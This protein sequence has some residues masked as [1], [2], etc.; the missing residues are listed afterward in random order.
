MVYY[1]MPLDEEAK[2]LCVIS[3]PWGLYPCEVLPQGVKPATDIF[4]QQMNALFHD[5][6]NVDT[7]IL[8]YTTFEAHLSD[9]IEVLKRSAAG[10]QVNAEKCKWFMHSAMHL[11]FVITR[12][13]IQPQLEKIQ[14]VLNLKRPTTLKEVCHFFGMINFYRDLYPKHAEML[15]PLTGLCRQKTKFHWTPEHEAAVKNI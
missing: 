10:M 15:A 2:K 11:G 9:V 4:Q 3:L 8:G 13:G 12:N 7:M 1:S 5:M 14:G 6:N